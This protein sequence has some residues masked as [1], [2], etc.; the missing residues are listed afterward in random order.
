MNEERKRIGMVL[1]RVLELCESG[2]ALTKA[3]DGDP[4]YLEAV[5]FYIRRAKGFIG[6]PPS[7]K[8]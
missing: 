5:A 6:A 2:A 3:A 7:E 1:K 8:S 4:K